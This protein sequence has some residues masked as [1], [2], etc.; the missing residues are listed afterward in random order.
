MYASGYYSTACHSKRWNQPSGLSVRLY[1]DIN[2]KRCML[3]R[4]RKVVHITY[5][6]PFV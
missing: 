1:A 3:E 5:L 6:L 4:R 2:K